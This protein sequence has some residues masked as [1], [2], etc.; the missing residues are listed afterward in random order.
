MS[1]LIHDTSIIDSRIIDNLSNETLCEKILDKESTIKL[2]YFS[3]KSILEI[4]LLLSFK[5]QLR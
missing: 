4:K 3:Q 2:M 5:S 1:N